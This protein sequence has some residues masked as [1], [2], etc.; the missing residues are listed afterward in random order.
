MKINV[1]LDKKDIESLI[2][3]KFGIL[4]AEV[5]DFEKSQDGSL[6]VKLSYKQ[7]DYIISSMLK[8]KSRQEKLKLI[9]KKR[10]EIDHINIHKRKRNRMR[11][12]NWH[13]IDRIN[14][15][16]NQKAI[17]YKE[18]IEVLEN[19]TESSKKVK[20]KAIEELLRAEG[21]EPNQNNIK[22]LLRVHEKYLEEKA[23]QNQLKG[24]A[25]K[26]EEN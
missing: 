12:S 17:V 13:K 20:M 10:L 11:L 14:I 24:V 6:L 9:K 15:R 25:L 7:P 26:K 16:S 18:V 2:R 21:N 5:T 3:G 1:L 8:T 23:K 22:Q 4:R 19:L